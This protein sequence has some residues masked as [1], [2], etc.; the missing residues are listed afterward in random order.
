MKG[1]VLAL[2]EMGGSL[3]PDELSNAFVLRWHGLVLSWIGE[4][5]V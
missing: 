5:T 2:Y 3:T 1:M 4:N